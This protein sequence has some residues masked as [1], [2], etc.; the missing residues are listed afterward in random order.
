MIMTVSCD[1]L[2]VSNT[3]LLSININTHVY[4]LL[5]SDAT[6]GFEQPSYQISEDGVS[7]DVCVEITNV[8]AE[9]ADCNITVLLASIDGQK[10]GN[11]DR[12]CILLKVTSSIYSLR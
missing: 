3:Q 12:E 10:A 8:P 1:H 11:V 4:L 7:V 6:I 2:R 5:C 9:G